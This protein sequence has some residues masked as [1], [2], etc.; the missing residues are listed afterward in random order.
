MNSEDTQS[1]L[2]FK[3]RISLYRCLG[4]FFFLKKN[5]CRV[6]IRTL[7]ALWSW[8][9]KG[10]HVMF[11]PLAISVSNGNMFDL[12]SFFFLASAVC[13]VHF[14]V[15]T[16]IWSEFTVCK[17]WYTYAFIERRALSWFHVQSG[18]C[19]PHPRLTPHCRVF[20]WNIGVLG[21]VFK[22]NW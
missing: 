21:E 20:Q 6:M 7:C 1:A 10:C 9:T 22:A 2:C 3:Y 17:C 13:S 4:L 15:L 5:P 19:F 14:N 11:S 18:F 8:A 16:E 12:K